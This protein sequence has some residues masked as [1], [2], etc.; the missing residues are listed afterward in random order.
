MDFKVGDTVRMIDERT[1]RG[2]G[3]WEKVGEVIEI[4]DDGT[5]IKRISV[6]FPDAEP[7]IGMVSGQFELV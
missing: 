7:I 4:V 1:A 3:V 6:K 5:S 2:F